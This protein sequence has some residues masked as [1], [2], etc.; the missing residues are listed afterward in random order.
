MTSDKGKSD[1]GKVVYY[2]YCFIHGVGGEIN[3][4]KIWSCIDSGGLGFLRHY[5]KISTTLNFN[6][7]VLSVSVLV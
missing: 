3:L 5:A 2:N 1:G 6:S 4:F 7:K